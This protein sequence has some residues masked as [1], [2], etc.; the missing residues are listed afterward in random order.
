MQK[1]PG[2]VT[3]FMFSKSD[4]TDS[5]ADPACTLV[6]IN[7]NGYQDPFPGGKTAEA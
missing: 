5:G 6:P 4:Q 3:D 7:Y 2:K 1:N